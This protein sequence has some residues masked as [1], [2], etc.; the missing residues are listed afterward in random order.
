MILASIET[1]LQKN[2]IINYIV[3]K[4]LNHFL[5]SIIQIASASYLTNSYGYFDRSAN[6]HIKPCLPRVRSPW[7]SPETQ[8]N[9]D[10]KV[11]ELEAEG[12]GGSAL[13]F[14]K[15]CFG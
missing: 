2:P 10:T 11:V 8:G 4:D 5:L 1:L 14:V 7:I 6:T 13:E 9:G 15:N 12:W 3:A